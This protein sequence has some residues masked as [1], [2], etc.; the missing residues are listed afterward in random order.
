M[1]KYNI[2]IC[3]TLSRTLSVESSSPEE[4]IRIAKEKYKAEEIILDSS[5]YVDTEFKLIK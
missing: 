5:N 1:P 2:E 4:A 3:E